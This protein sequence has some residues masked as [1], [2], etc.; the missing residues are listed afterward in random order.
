M[1]KKTKCS[2]KVKS[3]KTQDCSGVTNVSNIEFIT[4]VAIFNTENNARF[5]T[6]IEV[7]K[8]L[9]DDKF[10]TN[11]KINIIEFKDSLNFADKQAFLDL[12]ELVENCPIDSQV[13]WQYNFTALNEITTLGA[14]SLSDFGTE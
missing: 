9:L 13:T 3:H 4:P 5:T 12:V 7:T 1:A 6:L 14:H 11:D 2:L 10:N 8:A